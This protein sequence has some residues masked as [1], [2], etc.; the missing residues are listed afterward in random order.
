MILKRYLIANHKHSIRMISIQRRL[1]I[2]FNFNLNI[3][4]TADF[5]FVQPI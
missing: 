5:R 4:K 3:Y 1:S 2:T